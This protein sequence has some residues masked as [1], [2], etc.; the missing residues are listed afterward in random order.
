MKA[1]LA[2]E[3]LYPKSFNEAWKDHQERYH[4]A[5][6]YVKEGD[7]V[8]DAACGVGYGS[9]YIAANSNCSSV[10]ALDISDEALDWAK[11]YF[12]SDKVSYY[13]VDLEGEFADTLPVKQYDIVT[14]FE[15]IEH[16]KEDRTFLQQI[17]K[18][19]K[20]NGILLISAPDEDAIPCYSN[21]YFDEGKNPYHH[22]HYRIEEL[23]QIV[24]DYGFVVTDHYTQYN[25][26]V[27][28]GKGGLVN[29]LV[30]INGLAEAGHINDIDEI[31]QTCHFIR[32]MDN[33]IIE[34]LD[35]AALGTRFR[36]ILLT[37]DRLAKIIE[38]NEQGEFDQ[39]LELLANIDGSLCPERYFFEGL[40]CHG[41]NNYIRAIE[42]YARVISMSDQLNSNLVDYAKSL[43]AKAV[44]E[45]VALDD[46][47]N[48]AGL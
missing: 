41:K 39:C 22:R 24:I 16:L 42:S 46:Q 48:Y 34:M 29:I 17:S 43:L 5:L 2:L 47:R 18:L 28:K 35:F 23:E 33:N 8:L 45:V 20:P 21:P 32:A 30:C 27:M 13:K 11:K 40:A 10:V 9:Y 14:C 1:S 36:Q 44:N 3:R 31:I 7:I 6:S 15:T 25:D 37:Y 4:L 12:P 19:L 26:I 38:L